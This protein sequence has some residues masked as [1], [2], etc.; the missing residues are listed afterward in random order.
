M[1]TCLLHKLFFPIHYVL[2]RFC[3]SL[4]RGDGLRQ[5]SYTYSDF[6]LIFFCT[7][8]TLSYTNHSPIKMFS[9]LRTFMLDFFYDIQRFSET[10]LQLTPL[11]LTLTLDFNYFHHYFYF[12]FLLCST[13]FSFQAFVK[14]F[15]CLS[16]FQPLFFWKSW[17]SISAFRIH[18]HFF[19]LFQE[20]SS[21]THC[22]VRLKINPGIWLNLVSNN[23]RVRRCKCYIIYLHHVWI[24]FNYSA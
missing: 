12:F 19:S 14:T 5:S 22:V 16:T 24:V 3:C 6:F 10:F 1:N 21:R 11:Q 4:A 17:Q 20:P 18:E 9:S 13:D 8:I 23:P 7:L 15:N 2:S